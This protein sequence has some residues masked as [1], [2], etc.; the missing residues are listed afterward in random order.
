MI[1]HFILLVW[2]VQ[3]IPRFLQGHG[4]TYEGSTYGEIARGL[5]ESKCMDPIFYFDELDKV[6][7]DGKGDEVIHALIHLTDPIQN[8]QFHDR[9]FAGID[10]DVSRALFVFSYN[11][12]DKVNPILRDRIHEITLSDFSLEE[13]TEIALKYVL[14]KISR[15]MSLNVDSLLNFSS[16]SLEHLVNLCENSTGMRSLKLVLVRLLRILNLANISARKINIK[17]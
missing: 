16:G 17:Y 2:G 7:S 14:P 6:S 11:H 1:D 12:P 15:G 3:A 8:N 10:L 13:K 4:Y 9:Y 5:I